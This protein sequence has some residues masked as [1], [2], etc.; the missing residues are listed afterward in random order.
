MRGKTPK[1]TSSCNI[2]TLNTDTDAILELVRI[3]LKIYTSFRSLH[4]V[5]Y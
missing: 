5:K 1:E 3:W 4:Y 2:H